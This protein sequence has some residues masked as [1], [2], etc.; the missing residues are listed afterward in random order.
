MRAGDALEKVCRERPE[1]FVPEADRVLTHMGAIAQ[2]SVQWH[3]AQIL[4]HLRDDLAEDQAAEAT[5]LLQRNLTRSK[6]WIVLNTTMDVLA[7]WSRTDSAL[8]T[9]LT[10]ELERLAH[11]RRKAVAKRAAKRLGDISR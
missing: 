5:R 10:S 6:D 3:V 1:W 11:D 7:G 8:A 9:W 2:P 4:D